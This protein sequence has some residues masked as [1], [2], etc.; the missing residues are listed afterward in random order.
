MTVSVETGYVL[1]RVWES[2]CKQYED[3]FLWNQSALHDLQFRLSKP[4]NFSSVGSSLSL[5]PFFKSTFELFH[6]GLFLFWKESS[7]QIH[8][9]WHF[10]FLIILY[11]MR[12][13]F[14]SS[15][16]LILRYFTL[17]HEKF[18]V[19]IDICSRIVMTLFYSII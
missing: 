8:A 13:I 12:S 3:W 16:L 1:H 11:Q 4:S 19:T 2:V 7:F 6:N 14:F 9:E 10:T 17:S 5:L 18:V 15:I